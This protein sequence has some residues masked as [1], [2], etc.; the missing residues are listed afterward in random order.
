MTAL[1]G[2]YWHATHP[3]EWFGTHTIC[4]RCNKFFDTTN[5]DDLCD[6]AGC[7]TYTPKLH[8]I[9]ERQVKR[10]YDRDA[11]TL[12]LP[13]VA[14]RGRAIDVK[15]A[16]KLEKEWVFVDEDDDD[17]DKFEKNSADASQYGVINDA[18]EE[19][20]SS[21]DLRELAISRD[22]VFEVDDQAAQ[23]EKQRR[24]RAV[25]TKSMNAPLPPAQQTATTAPP[26]TT[27]IKNF[28][29]NLASK[30][31]QPKAQ[32]QPSTSSADAISLNIAY[33]PQVFSTPITSPSIASSSSVVPPQSSTAA[34]PDVPHPPAYDDAPSPPTYPHPPD[35]T[36]PSSS[37]SLLALL[38]V[39]TTIPDDI[40]S[41]Q[42]ERLPS[43]PGDDVD[44]RRER[45]VVA[46]LS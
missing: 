38:S 5:A 4:Q 1:L 34:S 45:R 7:H 43:E 29:T 41:H 22:G 44:D 28:F 37:A 12:F 11:P 31:I 20:P 19:A 8:A 42:R 32:Q 30:I 13:G 27:A 21:A 6:V 10:R 2:D 39:P 23:F 18:D 33:P 46:Q 15:P 40:A 17:D 36:P 9:V 25:L 35:T 16:P 24:K 3:V 26:A 14:E